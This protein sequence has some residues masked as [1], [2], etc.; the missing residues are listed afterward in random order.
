LDLP[1]QP[2]Q[3]VFDDIQKNVRINGEIFVDQKVSQTC[4]L[5]PFDFGESAANLFGN[6]LD[7]LA[8]N[9]QIAGYG[10][11][12]LCI[13]K[14]LLSG[15]AARKR[16]NLVRCNDDVVKINPIIPGHRPVPSR[17]AAVGEA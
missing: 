9:F 2:G 13:I 4:D 10:V 15:Q 17:F 7:G 3:F 14:K 12:G 5:A 11:Q 6:F 16:C 8:D 1:S